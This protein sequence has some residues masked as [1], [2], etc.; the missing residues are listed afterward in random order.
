MVVNIISHLNHGHSGAR[1]PPSKESE[2]FTGLKW[3]CEVA[4]ADV[5]FL[6]LEPVSPLSVNHH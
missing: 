1:G 3:C 5:G 6:K 2:E 4:D